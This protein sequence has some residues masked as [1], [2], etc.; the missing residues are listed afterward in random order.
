[1]TFSDNE[2]EKGELTV[3][4]RRLRQKQEALSWPSEK[5]DLPVITWEDYQ[6]QAESR[7]LICIAGYI[8]DVGDFFDK[9]PGGAYLL[10]KN[11][12]KDATPAF[13]G[14]LYDH[15]NSAH[16]LLAMKRVGILLGPGSEEQVVPPSQHL[17]VTRYNEHTI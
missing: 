12:G 15:G 17:R 13:F 2:V 6:R 7:A 4:L 10:K 5:P 9:H 11:I 3:Q 14:G 8:H 16:N 1:Q